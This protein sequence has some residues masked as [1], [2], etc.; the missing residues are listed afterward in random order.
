MN[1]TKLPLKTKGLASSGPLATVSDLEY[2]S[3]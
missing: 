3:P 1:L 2:F